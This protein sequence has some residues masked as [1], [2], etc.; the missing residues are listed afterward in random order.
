MTSSTLIKKLSMAAAGTAFVALG[1][2]LP[3]QANALTLVTN[4]P[5]LGANDSVDWGTLGTP[6]T[7]VSNPFSITSTGGLNLTVD[8]PS[9]SFQRLDQ[10]NGWA[11]N[12]APG[13]HLLWTQG[14][15]GPVTINF[16][17]PVKGA[18]AQIQANFFGSFNAILAFDSNGINLGSFNLPGNSNSA[19]DNS[20]PFIGVLSDSANIS[21]IIFDISR[22][23]G[24]PTDFAINQ[25]DIVTK[26]V[27]EPT[28]TLG[29]LALGAMGA[30]SAL[31]RKNG[32]NTQDNNLN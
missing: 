27:P 5:D 1:S 24:L 10:N 23:D 17:T 11:G 26:P 16:A 6:F 9:G 18:G 4:R 20:A 22:N 25:L 7:T 29:L 8:M 13:D 32:Q 19:G 30:T 14:N 28:S 15:S 12:F 3:N 21:S 2:L 31:K